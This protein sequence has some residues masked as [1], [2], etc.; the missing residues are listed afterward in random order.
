M[1][2][3]RLCSNSTRPRNRRASHEKSAEINASMPA[4]QTVR[5]LESARYSYVSF[6]Q[7]VWEEL[8]TFRL[9]RSTCV[10]AAAEN[11]VRDMLP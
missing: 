7:V 3:V 9:Q 1:S 8:R 5:C 2:S 4:T 10:V 6:L 11:L